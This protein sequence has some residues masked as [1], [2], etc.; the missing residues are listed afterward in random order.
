MCIVIC[1]ISIVY[2]LTMYEWMKCNKW[3]NEN[4]QKIL[5]KKFVKILPSPPNSNETLF[6][7]SKMNAKMGK[8]V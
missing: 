6:S 5:K 2:G 7:M 1:G 3:M 4:A 8:I